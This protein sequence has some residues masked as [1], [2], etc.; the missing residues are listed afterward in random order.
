MLSAGLSGARLVLFLI[1]QQVSNTRT[2]PTEMTLPRPKNL[3]EHKLETKSEPI[4]SNN[5]TGS[6]SQTDPGKRRFLK[7]TGGLVAASGVAGAGL[8]S[9]AGKTFAGMGRHSGEFKTNTVE[10]IG[11][12]DV[13][14][15]FVDSTHLDGFISLGQVTITNHTDRKI[16]I[17][18]LLPAT[19]ETDNGVYDI[20]ACLA[21]SPL[22]LAANRQHH[23]WVKP[24]LHDQQ[25]VAT[26]SGSPS[27]MVPPGVST[28]CSTEVG[29]DV[30]NPKHGIG[31]V[32]Q[33]CVV[34]ANF[35]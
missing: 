23:Y 26:R 16:K 27:M 19:I 15:S 4:Q 21:D 24:A 29:L 7:V 28:A 20:N 22:E 10:F 3:P 18:E 35:V 13:S 34:V 25:Y 31:D 6:H 12:N 33:P 17:S 1:N 9:G 14:I 2:A 32:N 8:L 5:D 11:E 30:R